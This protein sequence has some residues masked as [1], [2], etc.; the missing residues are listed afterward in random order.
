[1]TP[2]TSARLRSAAALAMAFA[3]ATACGSDDPTGPRTAVFATPVVLSA[4]T[5]DVALET[6]VTASATIGKEGGSLT[7][8]GTGLTVT[9]PAG[10]VAQ[11]VTFT[12]TARRGSLLAYEFGPAGATFAVPLKV[13]QDLDFT[14][15]E[16]QGDQT[17][18]FGGYFDSENSLNDA[19]AEAAVREVPPSTIDV[20]TCIV[21][22]EVRHFSGYIIATGRSR[23]K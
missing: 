6:D 11:P 15:W 18:V 20:P 1:M 10:A 22:F 13:S 2:S 14:S 17:D 23:L 5:R 8:P 9:V 16:H 4:V 19:S 7:I 21:A 12:A 3:A